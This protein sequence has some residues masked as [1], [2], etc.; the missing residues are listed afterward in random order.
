MSW[1][2]AV[3]PMLVFAI[4]ILDA[5]IKGWVERA[6]APGD[7]VPVIGHLL[8]LTLGYNDGTAFGVFSQGGAVLLAGIAAVIAVLGAWFVRLLIVLPED[9]VARPLALIRGSA[10]SNLIDRI[11]DGHVTDFLD[12]GVNAVRWPTFNVADMAI[13]LGLAGLIS[14]RQR[15]MIQ[16]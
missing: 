12:V 16:S 6:L 1:A 4:V 7:P 14:V 3:P 9:P 11:P 5:T 2:R 8:R 15:L 13:T 10:V